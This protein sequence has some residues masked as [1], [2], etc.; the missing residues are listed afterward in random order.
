MSVGWLILDLAQA[1]KYDVALE[2]LYQ[3]IKTFIFLEVVR[4]G[5]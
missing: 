3:Y 1:C 5:L 2:V 4:K